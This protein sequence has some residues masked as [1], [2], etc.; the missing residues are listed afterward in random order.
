MTYGLL[1]V[2]IIEQN[3]SYLTMKCFSFYPEI[4]EKFAGNLLENLGYL[5]E[6]PFWG[7]D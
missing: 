1:K 6:P 7:R 4:T 2:Y 3:T 5:L